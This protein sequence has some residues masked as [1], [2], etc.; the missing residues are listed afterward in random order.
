MATADFYSSIETLVTAVPSYRSSLTLVHELLA[1]PLG[2][3]LCPVIVVCSAVS[4][5]G[6]FAKV[7]LGSGRLI[8]EHGGDLKNDNDTRVQVEPTTHVRYV[9]DATG[10]VRDGI[11]WLKFLTPRFSEVQRAAELL[12]PPLERTQVTIS[13]T[14]FDVPGLSPEQSNE[15][16]FLIRTSPSLHFLVPD[17]LL[18]M[19]FPFGW[20]VHRRTLPRGGSDGRRRVAHEH[21]RFSRPQCSH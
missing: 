13:P 18:S 21:R 8:A 12:L 7:E 10:L 17:S 9:G 5:L 19:F 14:L 20:M 6:V 3:R 4:G 2:H 15:S 16:T 1:H 11:R